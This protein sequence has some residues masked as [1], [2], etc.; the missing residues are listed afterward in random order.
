MLSVWAF[1]QGID[2]KSNKI[3]GFKRL[4]I[5]WSVVSDTNGWL[6]QN[7]TSKITNPPPLQ[8]AFRRTTDALWFLERL[9][10]FCHEDQICSTPA[11]KED[12]FQNLEHEFW[13]MTAQLGGSTSFRGQLLCSPIADFGLTKVYRLV[14]VQG[15]KGITSVLLHCEFIWWKLISLV[16]DSL[17]RDWHNIVFKA[18]QKTTFSPDCGSY[19]VIFDE[20]HF[21]FFM[22]LYEN[23]YR[24]NRTPALSLP[25]ISYLHIFVQCHGYPKYTSHLEQLLGHFHCGTIGL[26]ENNFTGE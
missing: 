2:E 24:G 21:P 3:Q 4:S 20:G 8:V 22:K 15:E 9:S 19:H 16:W 23:R 18:D 6:Y 26:F 13:Y 12:Y 1:F 11:K 10:S 17:K 5:C 14:C 7:K 25:P